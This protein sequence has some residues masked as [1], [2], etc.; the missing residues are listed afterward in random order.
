M[1]EKKVET[2]RRFTTEFYILYRI[3]L[4]L[5]EVNI[6]ELLIFISESYHLFHSWVSYDKY[7]YLVIGTC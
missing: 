6:L 4:Q 5:L 1:D 2:C 3:V 7:Y